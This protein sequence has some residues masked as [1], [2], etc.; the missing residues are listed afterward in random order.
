MTSEK[1]E[2]EHFRPGGKSKSLNSPPSPPA[3]ISGNCERDWKTFAIF[4][5]RHY[6]RQPN[7]DI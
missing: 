2:K 1:R 4:A 7:T 5:A 6:D 3:K